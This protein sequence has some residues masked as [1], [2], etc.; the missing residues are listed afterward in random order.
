LRGNVILEALLVLCHYPQL[1][2][3]AECRVRPLLEGCLG[4]PRG[5]KGILEIRHDFEKVGDIF[6]NPEQPLLLELNIIV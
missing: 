1:R 4:L 5:C 2:E 6:P 3:L